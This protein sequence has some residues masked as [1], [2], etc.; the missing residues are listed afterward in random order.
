MSKNSIIFLV[1][2][3]IIINS[4]ISGEDIIKYEKGQSLLD[5]RILYKKEILKATLDHTTEKYGAYKITTD[6]PIMNTLQAMNQM[7]SGNKLNVFIALTN[8]KWEE[9]TIPIRIPIRKGLLSY[10][11]L[12]INKK[13]LNL[14]RNIESLDQ[15]KLLKV[16]LQKG[17]TT[18][19]ILKASNFDVITGT[20]YDGLFLM[21][22][23]N[24]FNFLPRGVN[25]IYS[26]LEQRKDK[27]SNIMIEPNLALY[28]LS[29]TYIFVS[30]D[31]PEIA[32]RIKEGL[33]LMIMDGT[34]DDIFHRYYD[35]YIKK[36]DLTNRL[37]IKIDNPYL[38]SE[39]PLDRTELWF[40]PFE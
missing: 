23:N 24:R 27:L 1:F 20:N 7:K 34:L 17:W 35:A 26:E 10:R 15:L 39:T 2:I 3:T 12:L 33:E 18:T 37:I 6:A 38:P 28:I 22:N 32:K 8:P 4:N 40:N 5:V 25:E 14:Y 11:L 30:L 16:G 21:L 13:D 19:K 29:P 36:A 31:F 9:I